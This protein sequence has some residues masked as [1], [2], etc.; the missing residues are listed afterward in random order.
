[1][2]AS[3]VEPADSAEATDSASL[4]VGVTLGMAPSD[5]DDDGVG[6]ELGDEVEVRVLDPVEE[7]VGV[8]DLLRVAGI[9]AVRELEAVSLGLPE[10]VWEGELL[11][12][13]VEVALAVSDRVEDAEREVVVEAVREA[14]R[15]SDA[16]GV[17][18]RVS[19]SAGLAVL[20]REAGDPEREGVEVWL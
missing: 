7:R 18:V 6:D 11:A 9:D 12:E 4:D 13:A 14:A 20:V 17:A 10:D 15:L 1:M 19:V 2:S 8:P 5:S 3:A 16:V